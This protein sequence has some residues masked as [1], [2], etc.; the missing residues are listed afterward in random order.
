RHLTP[1]PTRRSSDLDGGAIEREI[2]P[3][4]DKKFLIVIE[5]VEAAFQ[6]AEQD[7]DGLNALLVGEVLEALFLNLVHGRAAQAIGFRLQVQDRKST[8]LNSSHRT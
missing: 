5:H 3:A 7:R 8:R 1:F 2:V 6:V 4:L